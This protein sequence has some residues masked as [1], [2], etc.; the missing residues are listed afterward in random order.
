[1][2]A[3]AGGGLSAA[4]ALLARDLGGPALCFQM[5]QIPELDDR[6]ETPSMQKSSTRRCGTGRWQCRAG[7]PTSVTSTAPRRPGPRGAVPRHGP[8]RVAARLHLDG[9]ARPLRDE[10]IAYALGLLHAGVSVSCTNSPARSTGPRWSRLRPSRSGPAR[11][12]PGGPPGARGGRDLSD[13]EGPAPTIVAPLP[14]R[15]SGC[16]IRSTADRPRR[17]G[18]AFGHEEVTMHTRLLTFR[19][20]TNIDA[21]SITFETRSCPS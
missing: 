15:N 4:V 12:G 1:M 20:A 2:G 21:G 3:S 10:G 18:S 7:R 17:A 16:T 6:L 13:S 5:L 8:Q 11:V 9:R 14:R 19:G